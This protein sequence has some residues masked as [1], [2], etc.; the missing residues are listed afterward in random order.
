MKTIVLLLDGLGD[1]PHQTLEGKT[2]LE[3]AHTPHLDQLCRQAET[4]M[5][6]PWKLGVPMGTEAAHF[7]LLGYDIDD[8]PGRGI[9]EALS[10]NIPLEDEGVYVATSWATVEEKDGL[11]I[12]ER[13][14]ID[15]T[16]EEIQELQ[17]SLPDEIDGVIT[18]W[19]HS[20]GPHGVLHLQGKGISS[21]ISDSD[22]FRH[23]GHILTV[24][25]YNTDAQEALHTAEIMNRY[26][27]MSYQNLKSHPVN[28]KRVAEGK[29]AANFLL[30]KW[31]SQKPNLESF[32]EI[33]GMN[34]CMVAKGSLMYGIS[35]LLGMAF[36]PWKTFSEGLQTALEL[37]HEFVWL[38]TKEPDEAAHTKV[39]QS[40]KEVL[41]AIDAH[42]EPL[43]KAV[44]KGDLLLVVTG[45]HTTPSSG[46]MIHSGEAVP[47]MFIGGP[48]RIDDVTKFGERS[49]AKGSLRMKGTD[50]IPIILNLTERAQFFN[51]RPGGKK[52]RYIPREYNRFTPE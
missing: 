31:A 19:T 52:R 7:L 4:G 40:K 16:D 13:W 33:N 2:P 5:M 11:S 46:S 30:T 26:L 34:G 17:R 3:A 38:H 1:I 8:F 29:G 36:Y 10:E 35:Q 37:P 6:I 28:Q 43:V 27:Q 21:S 50:L 41:E 39:P 44:K 12:I 18:S 23:P 22:P 47:I 49:C 9:I 42:L 45:D 32:E 51:F 14:T 24:E 48:V 15:L 25:A 20:A